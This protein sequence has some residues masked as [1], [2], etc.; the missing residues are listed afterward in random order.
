M[1][2][3]GWGYANKGMAAQMGAGFV[4]GWGSW[5]GLCRESSPQKN[6][7]IVMGAEEYVGQVWSVMC[8]E[9]KTKGEKGAGA[10]SVSP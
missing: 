7:R 2:M 1:Q 10:G 5:V 9:N 8:L 4:F 6:I 3:K